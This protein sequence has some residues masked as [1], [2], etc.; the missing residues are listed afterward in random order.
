VL[1]EKLMVAKIVKK[2]PAFYENIIH[3]HK[4][5]LLALPRYR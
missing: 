5:P 4:S 3:E 2:F 1:L